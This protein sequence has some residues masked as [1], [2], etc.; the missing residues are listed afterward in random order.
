MLKK[1]NSALDMSVSHGNALGHCPGGRSFTTHQRKLTQSLVSLTRKI[2]QV[3]GQLEDT[4]TH[5]MGPS[6]HPSAGAV[7]GLGEGSHEL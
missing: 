6:A 5:P 1:G 7:R 3:S 2:E 4:A